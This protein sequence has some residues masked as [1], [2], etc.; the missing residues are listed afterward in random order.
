[1]LSTGLAVT[2]VS[3]PSPVIVWN[4]SPSSPVGLYWVG[5]AGNI[6]PGDIAVAWPPPAARAMAARRHYLP[7]GIPLVK[8]VGAVGGSRV[9]A[10]GRTIRVDGRQAASRRRAD[11]RGRRLPWWTGCRR[12]LA[13]EVLLL[14]HAGPQSF[15]GRY[16]GP[17]RPDKVVGEARLLWAR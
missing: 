16:F 10:A 8:R 11:D 13:G 1:M 15:D 2:L 6:R 9:C 17:T 3:R 12:L 7:A 4:A 5:G 14:S